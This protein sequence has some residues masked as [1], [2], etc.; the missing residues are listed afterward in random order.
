MR[1]CGGRQ[2]RRG[3]GAPQMSKAFGKRLKR[4]RLSEGLSQVE[5]ADKLGVT[6]PAVSN[7]E[8]GTIKP[9]QEQVK[10]LERVL[11]NL[12]APKSANGE[13]EGIQFPTGAFGA[14]LTKA[15]NE[16][17]MSV[18]EL[19]EASG[20]SAVAVYNIESRKSLNPRAETRKRLAKALKIEVPEEVQQEAT[21]AQEI[22][23]LGPLTD[24]DPHNRRD[25]PSASGVYVFYDVSDRPVYVGKSQN[26]AKRVQEHEV[27]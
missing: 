11:G 9:K 6:Q 8:A 14:W 7:W 26:I 27:Y 25:L 10:K 23:G 4:A 15:R 21:E 5:L 20:I 3:H 2:T 1:H 12:Q 16:A 19:A 22:T 18:P 24:F 17:G 13:V